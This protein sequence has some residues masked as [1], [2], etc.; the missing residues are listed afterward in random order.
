MLF[1][2]NADLLP[3]ENVSAITVQAEDAQHRLFPL[4][5]EFVGQ[6]PGFDW[7]T[8]INVKL[9]DGLANAGDVWLTISLRGLASNRALI[10][11]GPA[12]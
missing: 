1:A 10:N 5:V 4:P 2:A 11:I 9:P 3:G 12:Q 7:L 6:V 8:Q